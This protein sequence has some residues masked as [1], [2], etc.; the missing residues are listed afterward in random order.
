MPAAQGRHPTLGP[1]A[2]DDD[3]MLRRNAAW[4][5]LFATLA[6]G[7]TQP[8][9]KQ[10]EPTRAESAPADPEADAAAV[11]TTAEQASIEQRD[12]AAG[13][14]D[15]ANSTGTA[16]SSAWTPPPPPS[17]DRLRLEVL[18]PAWVEFDYEALMG[19]REHL[20]RTLQW[21]SWPRANFTLEENRTDL[22]RHLEEFERREAFAYTVLDPDGEECL[23]CIYLNPARGEERSVM[24]AMWV[25]EPELEFDL[26]DHLLRSVVS[27]LEADWPMD[28]LFVLLHEQNERGVE[29]AV[30]AGFT[31][32]DWQEPNHVVLERALE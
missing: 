9:S 28:R 1:F 29:V 2:G 26:D 19:S 12:R 23:G 18:G 16:W 10:A 8:I 6:C 20:R 30:A 21:G 25:I 13:E 31:P 15:A 5:A 27:W 14:A 11:A 24:L 7:T 32:A 3:V 4:L 17:T 22:A